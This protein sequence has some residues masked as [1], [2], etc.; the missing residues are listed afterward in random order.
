MQ[1]L[2]FIEKINFLSPKQNGFRKHRGTY[3]CLHVNAI[4]ISDLVSTKKIK[5]LRIISLY[6]AN[7]CDKTR[8]TKIITILSKVISDGN[9]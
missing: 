3:D 9:M 7:A 4:K 1:K 6:T 2:W 8:R 5:R